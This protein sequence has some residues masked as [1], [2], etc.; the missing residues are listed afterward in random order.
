[1]ATGADPAEYLQARLF[2]PVELRQRTDRFGLAERQVAALAQ[3][4]GEEL[5]GAPLQLGGEVDQH[6]AAEDEIDAREGGAVPQVVLAEDHHGADRLAHQVSV[7]DR[8]EVALD[9]LPSHAGQGRGRIDAVAREV[10]RFGGDIGGEDAD[11]Q[12]IQI[13]AEDLCDEDG[14][15]V[16]LL[17][18]GAP[19]R[20]DAQLAPLR[21]LGDEAGQ[22][23]LA[24]I[25]EKLRVAEELG[26]LDQ[27]AGNEPL[28]LV[29]MAFEMPPIV[30]QR[31]CPGGR[32]APL[33]AARDGGPLVDREIEPCLLPDVI[34]KGPQLVFAVI[35]RKEIG[36]AQ[37]IDEEVANRLQIGDDIDD[38]G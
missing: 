19:G 13:V 7:V 28:H 10:D 26:H 35:G 34:E 6:V 38:R 31:R 16:G 1:M 23:L 14:E 33:Q 27:E 8:H 30:E 4:E 3:R 32:H 25:G 11:R 21:R 5:E 22:N 17:A 37:K 36:A 2:Q 20:P 12:R 24:Q 29:R 15:G 9:D 18:G